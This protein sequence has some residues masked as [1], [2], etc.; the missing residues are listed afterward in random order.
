MLVPAARNNPPTAL[1]QNDEFELEEA[2]NNTVVP[3]VVAKIPE[4]NNK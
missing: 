3:I 4:N 2:I 1:S